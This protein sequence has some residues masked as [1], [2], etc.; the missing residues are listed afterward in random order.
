MLLIPVFGLI[1]QFILVSDIARSL[2]NENTLRQLP[3]TEPEPGKTIGLAMSI[4]CVSSMI[5]I[6]GAFTGIA[7]LVC[8]IV[9][10]VKIAGYSRSIA[11]PQTRA[12]VACD[13]SR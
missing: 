8:W 9:Y 3:L 11:A 5:P 13:R 4:L 7:G 12:A 1:W 6:V 10:W 2:A